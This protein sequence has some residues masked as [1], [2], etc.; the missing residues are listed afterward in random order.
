MQ[1]IR[2]GHEGLL[3]DLASGEVRAGDEA[4]SRLSPL[5]LRLL[6]HLVHNADRVVPKEELL[7]EVWQ[8]TRVTEDSLRQGLRVLRRELGEAG[9]ALVENVRGRGYRI[10]GPLAEEGPAGRMVGR[11]R[12]LASL[13]AELETVRAGQGRL[14]LLSGPPGIGKTCLLEALVARAG[15]RGFRTVIARCADVEGMPSLWPWEQV[16]RGMQETESDAAGLAASERAVLER[17]FP[18]LRAEAPVPG[19]R[20]DDPAAARAQLF[21]VL[22]RRVFAAAEEQPWLLALDDVHG[23]DAPSLDLLASLVGRLGDRR[24]ALV[25]SHRDVSPEGQPAFAEIAPRLLRSEVTRDMAL[26]PLDREAV[27][28]V[29]REALGDDD[30][31]L[32]TVWRESGGNPF[33]LRIALERAARAGAGR[34]RDLGTGAREAVLDH[35]TILSAPARRVLCAAAVLGMEV[36]PA[37][38]SAL[39]DDER[40]ATSALEE[41]RQAG[42][43]RERDDG[44]L[45]FVHA[46]VVEALYESLDPAAREG[47]HAR[48]AERLAA[49]DDAD[50]SALAEHAF[51]ARATLAPE[52]VAAWCERAARDANER[53]GFEDAARW[54]E[55]AL[56][57]LEEG[58]PRDRLRLVVALAEARARTSGAAGAEAATDRA[59]ALARAVGDDLAQARAV[60]ALGLGRGTVGDVA[61]LRWRARVEQALADHRAPTPERAALLW[62]LA[63]SLWFSPEA[64]RARVLVRESLA[65][66]ERSGDADV[67]AA[68]LMRAHRMLQ[69]GPDDDDVH[70]DLAARLARRL[71]D[72]R[73]RLVVLESCLILQWESLSTGDR[74]GVE[75]WNDQLVRESEATGGPH[76]RW[77]A[78]TSRA[79]MAH[80]AGDL[81]EAERQAE[82]GRALGEEAGIDSAFPNYMLQMLSIRWHR[83]R[84]AELEAFL[85]TGAQRN[86][87]NLGWTVAWRMAQLHGG[88]EA[89]AR[90]LLRGLAAQGFDELPRNVSWSAVLAMLTEIT[91]RLGEVP[92]AAG[93][94]RILAK[95]THRHATVALGF[96]HWGALVGHLGRVERLLGDLDAAIAHLEEGL[97]RDR[98]LGALVCV[99][100]DQL[101]LAAAL[102]ERG[103]PNDAERAARL[104]TEGR[105]LAED[106]GVAS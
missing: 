74:E 48:A 103:A 60:L 77:W 106:L 64:E 46:L 51:R 75:R 8:D 66:A 9:A 57:A 50:P 18:S 10:T 3:L 24:V 67:E 100:H 29:A 71:G 37:I 13:L 58:A 83:G 6:T 26:G 1:R 79:S 63:E 40:A 35:L 7:R 16:L 82:I 32:E 25:A 2:L 92:A 15:R 56:A 19:A 31:V 62:L 68:A 73:D 41:A 65:L 105:R 72:V 39:V 27:L 89:P 4:A 93:L 98:A 30:D 81:A 85:A 90:E 97:E 49:R 102:R 78:S 96:C 86:P 38:L 17:A 104:E 61:D 22:V 53:L 101:D 42:L 5:S 43:L 52:A 88:S 84:L 91:A 80:L 55:R 76:A 11:V 34:G 33:L 28:A 44:S 70:G 94:R 20:P 47:L 59:V 54:L 99:A 45:A 69:T 21:D 95:A 23:A 87:T 36:R 12:E 14:V